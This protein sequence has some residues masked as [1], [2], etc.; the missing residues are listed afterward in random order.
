MNG[1]SFFE[2]YV[3]FMVYKLKGRE[4][5]FGTNNLPKVGFISCVGVDLFALVVKG[6]I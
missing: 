2:T 6:H 5:S 4:F 3:I 1:S